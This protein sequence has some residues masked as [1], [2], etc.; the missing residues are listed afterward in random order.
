MSH[1]TSIFTPPSAM[2]SSGKTS[3]YDK[4][5]SYGTERITYCTKHFRYMLGMQTGTSVVDPY[6]FGPPRSGSI[7]IWT[8]PDPNIIK[9]KYRVAALFPEHFQSFT[10]AFQFIF[11]NNS[12]GT[13]C[14]SY[15]QMHNQKQT[16]TFQEIWANR[17][18]Q[19][20]W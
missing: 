14:L 1:W 3:S 6:V 10:M 11:L 13:H 2:K 19:E 12:F 4:L 9:Q 16:D 8:D 17:K 5:W 18:L 7:I 15:I 20:Q